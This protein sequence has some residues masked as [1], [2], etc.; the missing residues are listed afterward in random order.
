MNSALHQFSEELNLSCRCATEHFLMNV[1]GF[2]LHITPSVFFA[3]SMELFDWGRYLGD[4]DVMGAP[5]SCFQHVGTSRVLLTVMMKLPVNSVQS[6]T[7]KRV[8]C[9]NHQKEAPPPDYRVT[10]VCEIQTRGQRSNIA[11]LTL[12]SFH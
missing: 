5:V 2:S 9:V 1:S 10:S 8:H 7:T 6:S 12:R 3:V 11:A 4:G